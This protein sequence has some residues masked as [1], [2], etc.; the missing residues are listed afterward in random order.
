MPADS[1][2]VNLVEVYI[3]SSPRKNKRKSHT[4]ISPG[5]ALHM[6]IPNRPDPPPLPARHTAPLS[7]T[8]H[9]IRLMSLLLFIVRPSSY[10]SQH[11]GFLRCRRGGG[12]RGCAT[13][14]GE[15]SGRTQGPSGRRRQPEAPRRVRPVGRG[16]GGGGGGARWTKKVGVCIS[17]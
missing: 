11:H 4:A 12:Q 13:R 7:P 17:S 6:Y 9:N 14:L 3:R 2:Q 1:K 15:R 8:K 10:S 5:H 16:E